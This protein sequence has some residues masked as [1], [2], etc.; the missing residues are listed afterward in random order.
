MLGLVT[1]MVIFFQQL[2]KMEKYK[3]KVFFAKRPNCENFCTKDYFSLRIPY[4]NI[5]APP[6]TFKHTSAKSHYSK[7]ER[8]YKQNFVCCAPK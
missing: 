3:S 7:L 8:F 2:E 1:L 6:L 5:T 4:L